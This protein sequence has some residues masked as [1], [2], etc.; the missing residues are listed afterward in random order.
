VSFRWIQVALAALLISACG[1]TGFPT[2]TPGGYENFIA[3]LVQ[4]GATV[5]EQVAGDAGCPGGALHKDAARFDV[6][7]QHELG[8]YSIYFFAWRRPSDYDAAAGEFDQCVNA[9]KQ[10]NSQMSFTVFTAPPLRVY[11]GD[12][13]PLLA[14]A[15]QT[16]LRE[17]SG[18]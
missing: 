9:A 7:F 12:W 3:G 5:T 17:A 18:Q 8:H 10:M 14:A 6:T 15:I 16:S 11:G 2:P 1:V 13:P 4:R